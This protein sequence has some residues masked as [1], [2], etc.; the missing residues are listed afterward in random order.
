SE[1]VQMLSGSDAQEVLDRV[2]GPAGDVARE[3]LEHRGGA[4]A[5]AVGEHVGDERA[6]AAGARAGAVEPADAD[7]VTDVRPH[8]LGAGLDEPALVARGDVVLDRRDLVVY[9]LEQCAQHLAL[10]RI[11]QPVDRRQKRVQ[12]LAVLRRGHG[13]TAAVT[14]APAGWIVSSS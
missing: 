14:I 13:A 9:H 6:L 1:V 2:R 3:L 4:L 12:A 11:A 8:P 7:E 10:R 5:P